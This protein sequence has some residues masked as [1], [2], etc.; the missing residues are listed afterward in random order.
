MSSDLSVRS[1]A[2][3][4]KPIANQ[5]PTF[6]PKMEDR[7]QSCH[8]QP[9]LEKS[10][11]PTL[12]DL[13]LRATPNC[14]EK[15]YLLPENNEP[16]FHNFLRAFYPFQPAQADSQTTITLPLNEGDVILIHSIHTN[17]W[18]D[19]TLLISG[20]RGWLPTNYCEAYDP[21][22]MRNLL[23]GLLNFWDLLR[24]D[25]FKENKLFHNQEFI[26][27]IIAGVRYLLEK[28]DCL[29]REN[30]LIKNN[31]ILRRNR[32]SLLSDLSGLVKKSKNLQECVA[33]SS[34][35]SLQRHDL[36]HTIDEMVVRAF[37]ITVRG[38]RFL[39]IWTSCLRAPSCNAQAL[40]TNAPQITDETPSAPTPPHEAVTTK[41]SILNATDDSHPMLTA[42]STYSISSSTERRHT[43]S[44]LPQLVKGYSF[45]VPC[46]PASIAR[47][48]STQSKRQSI[49]HRISASLPV[50]QRQNLVSEKLNCSHDTLLSF[51][52]AFIGRLHLQSQSPSD[53]ISA[54]QQFVSAGRQLLIV[55]SA[56]CDHHSQSA[57]FL[58]ATK[59]AMEERIQ[60]LV[61]AAQDIIK[62]SGGDDEAV[63]MPPQKASLLTASTGCVKAAGE[64]VAKTKFFIERIGDFEFESGSSGLGIQMNCSQEPKPRLQYDLRSDLSNREPSNPPPPP[65]FTI[66]NYEK[67]LPDVPMSS[68]SLLEDDVYQFTPISPLTTFSPSS[69]GFPDPAKR[70]LL[71]PIPM[72]SSPLMS[73]EEYSSPFNQPTRE[74]ECRTSFRASS[75][76]T[77]HDGTNSTYLNSMR[78]SEL[79]IISQTSTRATTPDINLSASQVRISTSDL[80]VIDSPTTATDDV[81]EVESNMLEKTFAHELLL[82]KDGGIAGGTLP[83]LVERLTTHDSTP[84]S[85][86]V[87]TFYLTFRLFVNPEDFARALIERY[88]YVSESPKTS[89]PVRLRVY[90]VFK[91]W[92]ESHWQPNVDVPAIEI[93]ETF[94]SEKLVKTLPGASRRLHELIAIVSSSKHTSISG[95]LT[96]N[97]KSSSYAALAIQDNPIPNSI[98]SK[99]SLTML[100]NWKMGGSSPSIV[101]FDPLEIA[102]QLTIKGIRI[103][104]SILPEELLGSEWTKRSG[105]NATNVRAMA[106]LSTD[107][108]NLVTDTVLQ[109]DDA[110]KRASIIKHWIKIAH[111]CLELRNYDTLMAIICSMNCSTITRLKRTWDAVSQRRKDLLHS[112]QIV[113]EPDK[114]YAILR[115]KLYDHV[116]PCLPFVGMYLTDLTFVDAGNSPTRQLPGNGDCDGLTVINFD[117]HT[118]TAKIINDLQRFQIPYSLTE[119][120]ELQ[121]WIHSQIRRVKHS[122]ENEHVQ[123]LYRKSLLL[124]PRET[125]NMC[126]N[127]SDVSF[128]LLPKEKFDLFSWAYK[129]RSNSIT[130]STHL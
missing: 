88:D 96:N 84:D 54:I 46:G 18:A 77:S 72:M 20:S 75:I 19:G 60:Q 63:V 12:S 118:R 2:P 121:D 31:E 4:N 87:S 35:N 90:N 91:G 101:D 40:N 14:A 25:A 119:I 83:A 6:P 24:T 52:G 37:K 108:S 97:G 61:T 55:V 130:P 82:N 112:L 98:L 41:A 7:G 50:D 65:P 21:E 10:K 42:A 104:C 106:T 92:L 111:K 45:P 70:A 66:P 102:R 89:G 39:D 8:R 99:N 81:E 69:F 100:R 115:K 3:L 67:P 107:L 22:P 59:H 44:P 36:N 110:K 120:P 114:N 113:V 122:S 56:V 116:P 62:S 78:N 53:L 51:L 95:K 74:L 71:P 13:E 29:T 129:D 1:T 68:Y 11:P 80:S 64:C 126:R 76:A 103:F 105:S 33:L 17:G 117:K 16:V 85:V 9:T 27:G 15:E 125:Q 123:Q 49:S 127:H 30:E 93:I 28:T 79:S 32:K 47:P 86:F 38:V 128:P 5:D 34:L 94:A 26:R 124:E 48:T 73:Q 43:D 58:K 109:H 57:Q 23:S